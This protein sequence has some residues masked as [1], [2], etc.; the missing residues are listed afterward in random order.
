MYRDTEEMV[1]DI[2][3]GSIDIHVHSSI[4]PDNHWDLVQIA[5]NLE[6]VGMQGAV[7]KNLY[8]SSH[9]QC[10]IVNRVLGVE[11]L[12]GS[13]V[14][15]E[16]TGRI[17]VNAV[18]TF[19]EFGGLNKIVELPVNDSLHHNTFWGKP[20]DSGIHVVKD[21]KAAPGLLEVLEKIAEKD[22]ILKTGHISPQETI[23]VIRIAKQ[24]G[25]KQIIVTHATGPP[26]MAT[27]EQ[28]VAMVSGGAI[29]EHCLGK[30]LPISI[31]KH[32]KKQVD[33]FN[34][35]KIGDLEY[36]RQSIITVG[37]EN[38]LIATD[39]SQLSKFYPHI[40]FRYFVY[41]L[42]E[43][44]FSFEAIRK[45]AKDNPRKILGI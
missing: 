8:G 5:R 27:I 12:Y 34:G 42:F 18:K 14:L 10:Y 33:C 22:L 4:S 7:I 44:G 20:S 21:G 2:L 17:N 9:E 45:M 29:I 36:L 30:F 43:M 39:S 38:C 35:P 28:Q 41:L 13:I 40:Q 31:W 15:G 11:R 19:A 16:A 26:V 32:T 3:K 1:N 25:V 6:S 23:D 24:I 37:P